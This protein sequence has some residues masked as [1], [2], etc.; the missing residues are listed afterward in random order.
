MIGYGSG[1]GLLIPLW[2]NPPAAVENRTTTGY[3]QFADKLS[4]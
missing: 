2:K 1:L 3:P 4:T